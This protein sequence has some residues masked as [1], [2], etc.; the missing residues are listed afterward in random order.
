MASSLTLVGL[1][2]VSMGP[3]IKVMLRGWA[4]LPAWAIRE[5]A[6][7]TCTHGWHTATTWVRRPHLGQPI[8]EVLDVVLEA[9]PAVQHAHVAGIVPIRYADIVLRQHRAH[10]TAQ[11]RGKVPG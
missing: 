4:G 3:A 1:M 5:A 8:D 9:E 7:S 10:E 11:Q 2:R 6:V